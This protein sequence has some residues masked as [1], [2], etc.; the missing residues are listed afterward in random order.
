[1]FSGISIYY[2]E[3][4]ETIGDNLKEVQPDGFTTVPRL[5]EKVFEKIMVKAMN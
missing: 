3:S 4:L 5:L 1:M 2:A